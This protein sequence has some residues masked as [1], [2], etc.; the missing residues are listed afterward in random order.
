VRFG[1]FALLTEILYM[2]ADLSGGATRLRE[3][4]AGR[5]GLGIEMVVAEMAAAYEVAR[6]NGM[7]SAGS[8]TALDIYAG[9][10]A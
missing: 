6:W 2:K 4:C 8:S 10:R 9:G 5:I 7:T 3:R 1:R